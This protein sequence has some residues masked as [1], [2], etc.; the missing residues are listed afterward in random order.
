MKWKL[1][2]AIA[3]VGIALLC[4]RMVSAQNVKNAGLGRQ[5]NA[6]MEKSGQAMRLIAEAVPQ[7][8][9]RESESAPEIS[10]LSRPA[11]VE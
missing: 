10:G 8:F 5:Y 1:S 9:G 11:M 4:P 7:V 2:A 3:V 6:C